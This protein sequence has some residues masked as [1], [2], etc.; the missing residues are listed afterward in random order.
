MRVLDELILG[1]GG[2]REPSSTPARRTL[3][4]VLLLSCGEVT[5]HIFAMKKADLSIP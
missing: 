3:G 2:L 1:V 4:L 5:L